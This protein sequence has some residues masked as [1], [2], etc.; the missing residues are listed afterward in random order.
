M[1]REPDPNGNP[2]SK[3]DTWQSRTYPEF[4]LK[5]P[6]PYIDEAETILER[7]ESSPGFSFLD[8]FDEDLYKKIP[9]LKSR[10]VDDAVID[11]VKEKRPNGTVSEGYDRR[12]DRLCLE[13][14][15][16]RL[17][18]SNVSGELNDIEYDIAREKVE[19]INVM[20]KKIK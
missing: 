10:G 5:V 6:K 14:L 18:M 4:S 7:I 19:K 12:H 2:M 17:Q 9:S 15:K 16:Y 20:L 13:V 8:S 3:Y 1:F 11:I